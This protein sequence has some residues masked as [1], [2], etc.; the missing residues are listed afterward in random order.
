MRFNYS[1][2]KSAFFRGRLFSPYRR[3][4][5]GQHLRFAGRGVICYE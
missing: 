5:G 4:H 2:E 3:Q 1:R